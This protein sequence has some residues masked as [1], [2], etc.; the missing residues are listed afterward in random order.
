LRAALVVELLAVALQQVVAADAVDVGA[1][2][3][4]R[5]VAVPRPQKLQCTWMRTTPGS[6]C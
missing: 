6:R 3:D 1:T 4:S 2:L 5:Q